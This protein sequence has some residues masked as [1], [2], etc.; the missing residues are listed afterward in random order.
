MEVVHSP[1]NFYRTARLRIPQMLLFRELHTLN[2]SS[3]VF[4]VVKSRMIRAGHAD[5]M[6]VVRNSYAFLVGD[7]ER[8]GAWEIQASWKGQY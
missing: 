8:K 4:R 5:R 3:I 1:V 6:G 7:H 2:Y